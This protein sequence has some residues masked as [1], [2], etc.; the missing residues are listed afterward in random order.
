MSKIVEGF[1]SN[2]GK[3]KIT[4]ID[5]LSDYDKKLKQ[6]QINIQE[7]RKMSDG[8]FYWH[9]HMVAVK[10]NREG[11]TN[12]LILQDN[13]HTKRIPKSIILQARALVV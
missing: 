11:S 6:K 1:V 8:G 4:Y 12:R 3:W 9:I 5:E 7:R 10:I 2:N 13:N